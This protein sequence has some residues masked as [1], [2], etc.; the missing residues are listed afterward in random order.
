MS[1]RR[2]KSKPYQIPLHTYQDGEGGRKEGEERIEDKEAK[3]GGP[4]G[5]QR[6]WRE[7]PPM[8]C[9]RTV[10]RAL[11]QRQVQQFPKMLNRTAV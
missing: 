8:S 6:K 2:H 9:R 11:P 1:S 7:G 10:N 5:R 4:A 3:R